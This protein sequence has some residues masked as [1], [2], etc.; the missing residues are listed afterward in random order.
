MQEERAAFAIACSYHCH[1]IY[2]FSDYNYTIP[3]NSNNTLGYL[4]YQ[5]INNDIYTQAVDSL[6]WPN[7]IPCNNQKKDTPCYLMY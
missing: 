1:V 7:N 2:S 6:D 3:P 4:A 5:F